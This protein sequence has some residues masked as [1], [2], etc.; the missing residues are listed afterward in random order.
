VAGSNI[1]HAGA[2]VHDSS[3]TFDAI[4]AHGKREGGSFSRRF[5]REKVTTF[6]LCC[7]PVLI[8]GAVGKQ[9]KQDTEKEA[10]LA[11]HTSTGK[12]NSGD[13]DA[14]NWRLDGIGRKKG[15]PFDSPS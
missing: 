12:R 2:M 5:S 10:R 14:Q 6:S 3:T 7:G 8:D 11:G 9:D 15:E 4:K 13:S 1:P